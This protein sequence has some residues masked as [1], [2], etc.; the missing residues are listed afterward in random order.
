MQKELDHLEDMLRERKIETAGKRDYSVKAIERAKKQ[1]QTRI[2]KLTD[3]KSASK[4]KDDLL[5]FEQ[6]GFDYLV[7]DEA[8]AYKNGFVTTKMTN[9]AGVTTRPSGR[10]ED[11]QMK[12]DYF[13]EQLGQ[14]HILFCT[15]TPVS[16]TLTE[17]YVMMRYLRPDL[18]R[19]AGVEK[20]DDWA[21]TFGDVVTKNQQAADGTLKLR[22]SFAKFANLPELMAMYKEFADV[23]S[24]DKLHLPRPELKT[25]KP[26]IIS[27]KATPEQ[28]AYV[29]E[30]AARSK[31][32]ADGAV[33]PRSDNM[34]KIT[35]EARLVGL[36]NMAIRSLY[37]KRG[38]DVPDDFMDGGE[39]KVDKC[40]ENVA[41][42]YQAH[43][44]DKAVQIIFSDIAVNADN[45]SFSVYDHIKKKL[46]EDYSIP[47]DEIIFAP[48]ADSKERENIFRDINEGKYRVVI[49]STG[50]LGTGANIQQNLYALHHIDV[51]WKPSDFEQREGRILRQGNH[52]PEV[53]I[54]NYV[55]EGTLDSYLYQTVTAKAR[56]IAQLLDDKAP[57]RVSEDCDEKVLT[58][59]EIQAAAEGNPDF[60]RRIELNN[61]VAELTMLHTE[62]LHETAA[63][64]RK[65]ET[66]PEQINEK[67]DL[68]S[69]IRN[70]KA[71][72]EQI[73]DLVLT[74]PDGKRYTEKKDINEKLLQYVQQQM[75][76]PDKPLPPAELNGFK[77]TVQVGADRTDC[78]FTVKRENM[79]TCPAGTTENQDNATRLKNVFENSI[80]KAEASVVH[81]IQALG[82]DLEQAKQRSEETSPHEMELIK[83][84][85]ELEKL[86]EKLAGLS[87]QEDEIL[88]PEDA[89]S[90]V[91]ETKA[92]KTERENLLKD[93]DDDDVKPFEKTEEPPDV[94]RAR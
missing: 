59:G 29:H 3:P 65:T 57:A 33:D 19:E 23:Q 48:K 49:A 94:P 39:S 91:T 51:P 71:A 60:R 63:A 74:M 61:E 58:F 85:E 80:P 79:Y 47:E 5:E 52:F 92:E 41:S 6:L 86:E 28:R 8:H 11:M 17:L 88:D 93:A 53:E 36:G 66:L 22:T 35:S 84:K 26:Q 72:A 16:N 42:I 75:K 1:L 9:V 31:A 20:F 64:I 24:A 78:Y 67:N 50:T 83:A 46:T 77:V 45:G 70:D 10:A 89:A 38:E 32:I 43:R 14:G 69:R 82:L 15:G 13:N 87:V 44:E 90:P 73:T 18:L 30:L 2:E 54:F 34:L 68:L 56:F 81:S 27:V 12:T 76:Q 25:G 40:I 55:T 21:A 4:A 62:F 7:C 37:A